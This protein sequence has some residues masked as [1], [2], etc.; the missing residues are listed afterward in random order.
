MEKKSIIVNIVLAVCVVVLFVLHFVDKGPKPE[1]YVVSSS[2]SSA[3]FVKLPIAYV[4]IDTLLLNYNYSKDL[5]EILLR[6]RE[7]A[8]ATLTQKARVLEAQMAEFQK[9]Y[10]NNAFLSEGSFRRQQQELQKKQAEIQ[11]LEDNLSQELLKE[12]QHMNER[13]RDTIYSFLRRYNVDKKYEMI[14][15][16]TM[17]DNIMVAAPRYNITNEV[18]EELNKAYKRRED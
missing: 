2:D 6:K 1:P 7:N 10:E 9:K 15:S 13:L 17:N 14:I 11:K 5:N 3:I 8:Q 16:N 18:I 4:N 12:Q